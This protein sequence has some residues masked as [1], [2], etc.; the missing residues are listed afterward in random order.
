MAI[1]KIASIKQNKKTYFLNFETKFK[2][3]KKL[4]KE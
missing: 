4:K 2:Q 3:K 1:F